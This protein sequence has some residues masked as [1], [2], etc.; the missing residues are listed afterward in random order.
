M[1]S[2]CIENRNNKEAKIMKGTTIKVRRLSFNEEGIK[3]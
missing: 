1:W 2:G 3:K